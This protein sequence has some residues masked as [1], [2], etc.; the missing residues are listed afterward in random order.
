[1]TD[2][3]NKRGSRFEAR[4]GDLLDQLRSAHPERVTVASQPRLELHDGEVVIPCEG[5]HLVSC[6]KNQGA[7]PPTP[8]SPLPIP[9]SP[10]E[11]AAAVLCLPGDSNGMAPAAADEDGWTREI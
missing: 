7:T 10:T 6:I 5:S 2:E 3:S 11:A 9:L 8:Y 1:M 4:V